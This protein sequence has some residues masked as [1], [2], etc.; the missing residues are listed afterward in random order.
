MAASTKATLLGV[1]LFSFKDTIINQKPAVTVTPQPTPKSKANSNPPAPRT[2]Q[3]SS[4]VSRTADGGYDGSAQFTQAEQPKTTRTFSLKSSS[5]VSFTPSAP[6]S[7]R[8]DAQV[9]SKTMDASIRSL[10][11][12]SRRVQRSH[13]TASS[14]G[15]PKMTVNNFLQPSSKIPNTSYEPQVTASTV[16]GDRR[17]LIDGLLGRSYA[18]PETSRSTSPSSR[19][20]RSK[21]DGVSTPASSISLSDKSSTK[22]DGE[23]KTAGKRAKCL[24]STESRRGRKPLS[25]MFNRN[26]VSEPIVPSVSGAPPLVYSHSTLEPPTTSQPQTHTLRRPRDELGEGFKSLESE[27]SR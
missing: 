16:V 13:S 8:K 23:E 10:S 24:Q 22:E 17:S 14:I 5:S 7:D 1:N 18:T 20:D 25:M 4:T 21:D 19:D 15:R 26:A 3:R 6:T 11:D 2:R 9:G 12:K 27:Y